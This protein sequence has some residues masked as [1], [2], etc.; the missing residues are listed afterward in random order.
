MQIPVEPKLRY[1]MGA[2]P[3]LKRENRDY[4]DVAR[5]AA[6]HLNTL[7]AN[8]ESDTQQ[9]MFANIARDIG[10]STDDVRSA[11]SNG[12]YDGITFTNISAE[13]RKALAPYR[14]DKR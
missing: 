3:K 8:N 9:Y 10:A 11:L 13:E 2:S 12:G 7:I 6:Y 1:Y 14:R 4:N 5:R